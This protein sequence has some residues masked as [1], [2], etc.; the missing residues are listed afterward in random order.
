MVIPAEFAQERP[1]LNMH[2][3][4]W[5]SETLAKQSRDD[6]MQIDLYVELYNEY[7]KKFLHL[8]SAVKLAF[9]GK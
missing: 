7:L 8:G 9:N 2:K 5:L 1:E 4:R 3:L 6:R